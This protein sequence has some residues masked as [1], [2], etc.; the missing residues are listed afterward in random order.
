MTVQLLHFLKGWL[1]N[2]I[3]G[4][5]LKYAPFLKDKAVA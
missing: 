3:V 4:S 5:D 1:Q 2:H